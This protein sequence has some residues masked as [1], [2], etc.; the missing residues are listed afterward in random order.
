MSRGCIDYDQIRAAARQ[1]DG[2]QFQ[3]FGQAAVLN[4]AITSSATSLVVAANPHQTPSTPFTAAFDDGSGEQIQVTGVAGTTWTVTRGYN[5]TMAAAHNNLTVLYCVP[6]SGHVALYDAYG[7]L[8]DGGAPSSLVPLGG[9]NAQTA[10][11]ALVSGDSGKLV[12][13]NGTNLTAKLPASPPSSTWLA[14]IENL[15]SSAVTVSGNGLNIN[16]AASSITLNQFDVI[17]V[18]TDG[19][20][21]FASTP[22]VAGSNITLTPTSSGKTI[23]ASGG[24]GGG[25]SNWF[26]SLTAPPALASWTWLNQGSATASDVTLASGTGVA[27]VAPNLSGTSLKCLLLSTPARPFTIT[28]AALSVQHNGGSTRAG[29]VLYESSSGKLVTWSASN[30]TL[31][32]RDLWNST[33]SFNSGNTPYNKI[34]EISAPL[35]F[36]RIVVD[37]T[38]LTYYLS[39]DQVTWVQTLQ[40]SLTAWFSS[41]PNN[42]GFFIDNEGNGYSVVLTCVHWTM[43]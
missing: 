32:S 16:G 17:Q 20:N 34:P 37:N 22:L 28:F 21:Y 13:M 43:M 15:N 31:R 41:G 8:Y 40:E 9:V 5:S 38:H 23:A 30:D 4:G 36:W 11:Y 26:Y 1:G 10:N 2:L 18:W 6:G 33:T 24:G 42:A 39:A 35:T 19:S 27:L 12:T 3:M 7:N 14:W 29:I 25:G